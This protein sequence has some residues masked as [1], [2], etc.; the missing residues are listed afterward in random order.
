MSD[1]ETAPVSARNAAH[2]DRSEHNLTVMAFAAAIESS[3]PEVKSMESGECGPTLPAF[4]RIAR[5][6]GQEPVILLVDVIAEWRA[7]PA[8]YPRCINRHASD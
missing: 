1:D 2:P 8:D 6:L 4:F 3:I 5:A 7:N